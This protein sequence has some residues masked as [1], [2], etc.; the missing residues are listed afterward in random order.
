MVGKK[1]DVIHSTKASSGNDLLIIEEKPM[2]RSPAKSIEAVMGLL[3][4]TT[5]DETLIMTSKKS[6][7]VLDSR[8]ET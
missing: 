2:T 5:M 3:A 4:Q 8:E 7:L 6:R 1:Y